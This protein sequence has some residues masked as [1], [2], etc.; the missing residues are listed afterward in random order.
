MVRTVEDGVREVSGRLN[1]VL[2]EASSGG[3]GLLGAIRFSDSC[4]L[5][6]EIVEHHALRLTGDRVRDID[7][8]LSEISAYLEFELNN[9]PG[10]DD[11]SP[12]LEAVESLRA[13]L[14]R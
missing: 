4:A 9:H 14:I 6:P 2:S 1:R 13:M 5:D 7:Q 12:Y 10:I 3:N 11:A 8:A